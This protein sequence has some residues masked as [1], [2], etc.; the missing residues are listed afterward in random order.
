MAVVASFCNGNVNAFDG[1]GLTVTPAHL[2]PTECWP[3]WTFNTGTGK[4]PFIC[5][6]CS[7]PTTHFVVGG[8]TFFTRGARSARDVRP[9]PDHL[10]IKL[11][12]SMSP[13]FSYHLVCHDFLTPSPSSARSVFS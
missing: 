11:S 7:T 1:S 13:Q 12:I 6:L 10:P 4:G 9:I 8:Y 5:L 3:P 2:P